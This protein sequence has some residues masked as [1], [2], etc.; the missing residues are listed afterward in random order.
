MYVK[1]LELLGF[2][3]FADK[4]QIELGEGITAVVGPNGS[5]KSN[6]SDAFQWV[7]GESNVRN[8]RGQRVTDVIFNG[9][10]KR[11]SHG[12]AEVSLTLD[13]CDR[14]LP[15]D[16]AEVT[17]TRR[18]YRSGESEYLINNTRCRL[19]DIYELFLDTGLGREAYSV[20]SQGEIDAVL[21]ARPEERRGLFEEAAGIRKYRYRREEALRKLERT[22]A[23]LR[24][25]CDIMSEVESQVEPMAEQA[26]LARR[27]NELQA[28]LWDIEIGLLIRDLKRYN[29]NLAEVREVRAEADSRKEELTRR[30]K[31]LS[32]AKEECAR[33][34]A[35]FDEEREQA[36]L[37]NQALAA[38]VQRL[39]NRMALL[40][41][42]RKSA[43]SALARSDADRESLEA[44]IQ[45][46]GERLEDL[47]ARLA[48]CGEEESRLRSEAAE[49]QGAVQD[50]ENALSLVTQS[51]NERMSGHIEVARELSAKQ[52]TLRNLT[53]RAEELNAVVAR[54]D[55]QI[56][57]LK[58]ESEAAERDS[59]S[60]ADAQRAILAEIGQHEAREKALR[61]ELAKI[62]KRIAELSESK[63]QTEKKA[64][65]IQSR[66][67]TLREMEEAR[68]GV[69]QGA[70]SL[71]DQ[72]AR[73]GLNT[74]FQIVADLIRV[75]KGFELAIEAALGGSAQYVIAP[76]MR[77]AAAAIEYLKANLLGQATVLPLD[78][79]GKSEPVS[80][81][82]AG[83][84]G[85]VGIASGLVECDDWVRPAV[86]ALL[87]GCL[88]V[89]DIR[90][91]FRLAEVVQGWERIVT[92]Q[93]ETLLPSGAVTGGAARHRKQSIVLRKAEIESLD[94][95]LREVESEATRINA[96]LDGLRANAASVAD[97]I[98][99]LVEAL[100]AKRVELAEC[101]KNRQACS[102]RIERVSRRMEQIG[103][104][105]KDAEN[106]RSQLTGQAERLRAELEFSGSETE[107]LDRNLAADEEKAGQIRS[108]LE[109][110]RS[111]LMQLNAS[112]AGVTERSAALMSAIEECGGAIAESQSAL[113]NS[114]AQ[115][116]AVTDELGTL[117]Q[118]HQLVVQ[119][120][121]RQREL[122]ELSVKT[123]EETVERR[124]AAASELSGLERELSEASEELQ[125]QS[126]TTHDADVKEARLEVQISQISERLVTE[127]ELTFE[128]A[129]EWPEEEIE[130]ERGTAAEVSRL[131]RELREM[132]PVNTGAVQEYERIK[133]RWEFLSSQ[134]ADL[135]TAKAQIEDGIKEI[136]RKTQGLFLETF[137][138]VASEFDAMFRLLFGGGRAEL[139]LSEPKDVLESGIE[140]AVQPPG[141]KL[142]D[143]ALLSGGERALAAAALVFALLRVKP[144][145]FVLLDEVDAP[146]DESNVE[147]FAEVLK[148][149]SRDSQ[150]VVITHNRA[151]MEA[152]G[153]LY[154]ITMEEP[155]ISKVISVRISGEGPAERELDAVV[156]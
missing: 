117:V 25:V 61:D 72:K 50:M 105:R 84:D 55:Q 128:K 154:G 73:S 19:K 90:D 118:E 52:N 75:A 142:Q 112:L 15:L 71:L 140:V 37:T 151:T 101:A 69:S 155:G 79:A 95:E 66:L 5:G 94:K 76:T 138:K 93:G 152:A 124:S 122:L 36:R 39:E 54:L 96:D 47:K 88:V 121:S 43:E 31:E 156:A 48:G 86:E 44:K 4:T 98:S 107:S 27:H 150:F 141:K 21:S 145:P 63:L 45:E 17:V 64:A 1:K 46:S 59:V 125:K 16:F 7:L 97:E 143:L 60:T 111:E 40:E 137:E 53:E 23:N 108:V 153:S 32:A 70:R 24:R 34:L 83:R 67:K 102:E 109:A 57:E 65:A 29:A 78:R 51:I 129:M 10:E 104:D 139:S 106:L 123:V 38:T 82:A 132:G 120:H 119:E 26:E 100:G 131:R 3:T 113:E 28:R 12:M 110:K 58:R 87:G 133:E 92:R 14:K 68:E 135:E 134:R 127:Y 136:D 115:A 6:I 147:R 9:S 116:K 80:I 103:S 148:E 41:E 74:D 130:V 114:L 13:N 42:R 77:D 18:A 20:I 144:S 35:R 89:E 56:E 11:R 62:D 81:A 85:V 99:A 149:F 22:E 30:I 126:E 33:K 91:A 2:K 49:M 8:L 146:L